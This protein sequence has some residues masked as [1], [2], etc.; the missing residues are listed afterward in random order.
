MSWVAAAVA[1]ASVVSGIMGSRSSSKADKTARRAEAARMQFEQQKYDDWKETYGDIENNLKVYYNSLTPDY[2]ATRGI[3]AFEKEQQTS[4]QA[5]RDNLE[6]RGLYSSGVAAAVEKESEFS[7]AEGR[8][9][10]RTEAPR[11]AAE[12]K[13]SFLQVGMGNNP[14]SSMSA[15]LDAQTQAATSRANQAAAASGRATQA[16]VE[17]VGSGLSDYL[18]RPKVPQVAAPPANAWDTTS[19]SYDGASAINRPDYSTTA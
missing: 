15:V 4:L 8:A 12:D 3:E 16:A 2:Y 14:D 1:G 19:Y 10:I 13:R 6:Q 9:R 11:L 5:V 17:A 18:R 7:L